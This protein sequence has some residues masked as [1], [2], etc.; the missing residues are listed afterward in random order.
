MISFV[1]IKAV[2]PDGGVDTS[3]PSVIS[4]MSMIVLL[5]VVED[6]ED[7]D[8]ENN[9]GDVDVERILIS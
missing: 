5:S 8:E 1:P 9:G 6:V 2:V 3:P 4:D 7:G